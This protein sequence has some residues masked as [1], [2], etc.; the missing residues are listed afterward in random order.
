MAEREQSGLTSKSLLFDL[1]GGEYQ[2]YDLQR[3]RLHKI[4]TT[5][6]G[7][8]KQP[9]RSTVSRSGPLGVALA[10]VA[11]GGH[12][13]SNMTGGR[14]SQTNGRSHSSNNVSTLPNVAR[15]S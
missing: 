11:G 8:S 15:N 14:S 1:L 2:A 6:F 13:P 12:E 3:Q 10:N 9:G 4:H 7:Q 5:R